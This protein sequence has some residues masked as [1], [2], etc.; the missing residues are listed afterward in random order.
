[1]RA[2]WIAAGAIGIAGTAGLGPW[3]GGDLTRS[4]RATLA[5][6]ITAPPGSP[7][8][9]E[10]APGDVPK[11]TAPIFRADPPT[12]ATLSRPVETA[13]AR[14]P[15]FLPAWEATV[16][17][18][19]TL[20]KLLS[21]AG[22]DAPARGE[23]ALAVAAEFDPAQLRPGHRVELIR[24]SDGRPYT[25]TIEVDEGVQVMVR[26]DGTPDVRIVQPETRSVERVATVEVRG[27]VYASLERASVPMSFAVDLAEILAGTVNF[28]R[29]LR[30]GESMRLLWQEE[31][32]PRDTRVGTSRLSYAALDLSR[33]RFEIVWPDD[34]GNAVTIY[35]DG[36]VLRTFTPPV[37]G[38]RLTSVFG[39]RRHP[40][41]G[42]VRMHTGV[43]F[44]APRG[45]PVY[46]TASG[47]V[48]FVGLRNGYGRVVEIAHGTDTITRYSHLSTYAEGL[49]VGNRVDAGD[50]IGAVGSS[51][52]ATGPNLHYEVRVEGQPVDPMEDERVAEL[53]QDT[54]REAAEQR[55]AAARAHLVNWL[56]SDLSGASMTG[57]TKEESL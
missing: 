50:L 2:R 19:D 5:A 3:L 20:D 52:L 6:E 10:P 44:A 27:S 35:M 54:D 36:Q 28:R 34:G 22:L 24:R 43:D 17:A 32:G 45:T 11:W 37:A 7:T 4:P 46:A 26:I 53:T 25:L 33:S 39:K 40:L 55:L 15:A 14:E 8:V 41:Y 47:R 16:I 23:L 21:R 29:D 31:L 51:G 9:A 12:L 42:N 30:G 57:F 13:P 49:E 48:A 38:A 18:G 56:V 1:M